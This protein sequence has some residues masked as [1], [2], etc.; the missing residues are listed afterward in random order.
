VLI[1]V[2]IVPIWLAQR[3]SGESVGIGAARVKTAER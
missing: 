1:V 3:L 2:S